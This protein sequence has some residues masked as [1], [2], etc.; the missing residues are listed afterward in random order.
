MET[1][2]SDPQINLSPTEWLEKF[3]LISQ[4]EFNLPDRIDDE[5]S[6]NNSETEKKLIA[7]RNRRIIRMAPLFVNQPRFE[8]ICRH[9]ENE[10]VTSCFK[11][12]YLRCHSAK[13]LHANEKKLKYITNLC[14]FSLTCLNIRYG[15]Y[16]FNSQIM[17]LIKTNCPNLKDLQL[18]LKKIKSQDFKNAF[19]NMSHLERLSIDWDCENSTLPK[20]LVKSLEKVGGTLKFLRLENKNQN[21]RIRLPYSLATAFSKLIVL[22]D[23]LISHFGLSQSIIDAIDLE[24]TKVTDDVI[25]EMSKLIKY[26]E[27]PLWGD[28]LMLILEQAY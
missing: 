23:V 1:N 21:N 6:R 24:N 11:T 19:S 15:H 8:K 20:S 10:F 26:R 7:Q 2:Q 5:G 25:N 17:P 28:Q 3:T 9:W 22:N 4:E 13:N 18:H 12:L 16:P 27:K 14:G